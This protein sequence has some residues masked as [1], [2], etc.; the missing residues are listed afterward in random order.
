MS[1]EPTRLSF[2]IERVARHLGLGPVDLIQQV[3][4]VWPDVAGT[5][6]EVSE[7]MVIRDGQLAVSTKDPTVAEALR[8]RSTT[9]LTKLSEVLGTSA[10]ITSIE[11]RLR[12]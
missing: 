4:D 6:A 2:G 11:V 10:V 5:L 3:I 9:L 12:R 7:P 8:W 1:D